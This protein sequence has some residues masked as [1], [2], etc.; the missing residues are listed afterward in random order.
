MTTITLR[1]KSDANVVLPPAE[2]NHSDDE[3]W[4]LRFAPFATE[5][6]F[7]RDQWEEV[8]PPYELPTNLGAIVRDKVG[9]HY[10]RLSANVWAALGGAG[11]M[12]SDTAFAPALRVGNITTVFEG[13]PA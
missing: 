6:V 2:L 8:D 11:T 4:Q 3:S 12:H 5:N 7:F 1:S 10:T 13:V 9:F